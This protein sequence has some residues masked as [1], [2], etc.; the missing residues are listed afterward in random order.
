MCVAD[1]V[2]ITSIVSGTVHAMTSTGCNIDAMRMRKNRVAKRSSSHSI[3]GIQ[4]QAMIVC[5][6]AIASAP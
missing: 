4:I 3:D 6:E 2:E 5:G 1:A